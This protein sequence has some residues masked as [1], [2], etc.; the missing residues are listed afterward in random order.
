MALLQIF[1][2]L[3]ILTNFSHSSK[4]G[5]NAGLRWCLPRRT[6]KTQC[7]DCDVHP[8]ELKM[9]YW[10]AK[11]CANSCKTFGKPIKPKNHPWAPRFLYIGA[12]VAL[13]LH[14]WPRFCT[15]GPAFVQSDQKHS[16]ANIRL[17]RNML[18]QFL[19]ILRKTPKSVKHVEKLIWF[20]MQ[21]LISNQ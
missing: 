21:Q 4:Y 19:Q 18:C 16:E 20:R 12:H 8:G 7:K 14:M 11:K 10:A 9:E 1:Y 17:P 15:C 3:Q 2:A 5:T 6:A 13:L